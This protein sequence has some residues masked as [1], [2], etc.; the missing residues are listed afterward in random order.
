MAIGFDEIDGTARLKLGENG[1][2]LGVDNLRRQFRG[3]WCAVE[4]TMVLRRAR[5]E[6]LPYATRSERFRKITKKVRA[7]GGSFF[8]S[9]GFATMQNRKPKLI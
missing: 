6:E 5:V 1:Q 9:S 4:P 7:K 8:E 2:A 3:R